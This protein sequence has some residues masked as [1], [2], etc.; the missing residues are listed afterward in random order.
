M[1]LAFALAA[2]S[3][4]AEAKS[5]AERQNTASR[6][7]AARDRIGDEVRALFEEKG[8][9][10]P[11]RELLLRHLKREGELELWAGNE[12]GGA[13]TLIRSFAVCAKSGELGPKRKAG[14]L[15]VPEGFYVVDRYNAWSSYHLSLGIDYPNDVDRIVGGIRATTASATTSSSTATA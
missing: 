15:Q 14:D 10:Y 4:A 11:A 9:S 1:P 3:P 13:M 5:F 12:R 2:A 6:V 8:I 7:V